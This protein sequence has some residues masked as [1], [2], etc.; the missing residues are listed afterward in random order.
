MGGEGPTIAIIRG[1]KARVPVLDRFLN[2]NGVDETYGLAP[3]YD[4][5]PDKRSRL[6]RSKFGGGDTRTRIFVPSNLSHNETNFAYVAWAWE[7]IYAQKEILLDQQLPTNPPTGWA[8]VMDTRKKVRRPGGSDHFGDSSDQPD[9]AIQPKTRTAEVMAASGSDQK[10]PQL[11]PWL[12]A[13]L[14][15]ED[16]V[17]DESYFEGFSD[18]S[19]KLMRDVWR[20]GTYAE[21]A[22]MPLENCIPLDQ[23]SL[24]GGLGYS[25]QDLAYMSYLLVPHA[26]LRDIKLEPGETIVVCPATGFYSGFGVQVAVAMGARVIAMGR[27]EEKLARLKEDIRNRSPDITP[28]SASASTHTKSAIKALRRG[29]RVSLMRSARNISVQEI[30]MNN[31]TLQGKNMYERDVILQFVKLLERGL[32][33][34]GK[35]FVDTK[36]FGLDNWK[37]AFDVAADY[38]GIGK[39]VV[40]APEDSGTA[41]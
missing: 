41:A 30:M 10:K 17:K 9:I 7:M 27:N 16:R 24:C 34:R 40:F 11:S 28:S 35:G 6:L 22:R 18:G 14:P 21:Y 12:R 31:L 5:D 4:V 38:N 8:A 29:G 1:L 13:R 2:A 19:R 20:N 26:G 25:L 33:P 36:S 37:E 23:T 39:C 15:E 32:F 3:F